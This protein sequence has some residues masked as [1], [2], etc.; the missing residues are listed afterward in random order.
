MSRWTLSVRSVTMQGMVEDD[1]RDGLAA[2]VRRA[3]A[4]RGWSRRVLADRMRL[5]ERQV[6]RIEDGQT[7]ATMALVRDL[8]EALDSSV[9]DVF[10]RLLADWLVGGLNRS[11]PDFPDKVANIYE[12][13]SREVRGRYLA[14]A[15]RPEIETLVGLAVEMNPRDLASVIEHAAALVAAPP[16]ERMERAADN[17]LVVTAAFPRY[18]QLLAEDRDGKPSKARKR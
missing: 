1:Y 9:F 17:S 18:R 12:L 10:G 6:A 15:R 5:P 2:A 4:E 11:E 3:R 7:P 14:A 8:A 13:F 16:D